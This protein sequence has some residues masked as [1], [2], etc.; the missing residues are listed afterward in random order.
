MGDSGY[1]AA[2]VALVL[3]PFVREILP[4]QLGR[5]RKGIKSRPKSLG[6]MA[7]LLS[8]RGIGGL[9]EVKR[10]HLLRDQFACQ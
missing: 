3:T 6:T 9:E 5:S 1:G 4:G 2:A 8:P 10:G 7:L